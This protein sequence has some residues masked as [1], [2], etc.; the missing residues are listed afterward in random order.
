[1]PKTSPEVQQATK[2]MSAQIA[3]AVR[4]HMTER[5]LLQRDLSAATG[6]ERTTVNKMLTGK[7]P[8]SMA[9]AAL[10]ARALGLSLSDLAAS[11]SPSSKLTSPNSEGEFSSSVAANGTGG[12][13]AF[14]VKHARD[15]SPV[16]ADFIRGAAFPPG[17]A[18]PDDEEF[19][20]AVLR[21][22]RAARLRAAPG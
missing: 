12:R 14:L 4:R 1:M 16:E 5:R 11:V 15:L 2:A 7:L 10:F 18:V 21:A 17:C 9:N 22:Y 6:I 8:I 3:G 20:A 13:G 19:W